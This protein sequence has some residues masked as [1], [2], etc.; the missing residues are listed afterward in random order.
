VKRDK[1][2]F[3]SDWLSDGLYGSDVRNGRISDLLSGKGGE[4]GFLGVLVV[5]L[6]I[7]RARVQSHWLYNSTK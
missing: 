4:E 3:G 2:T 1:V 5:I 7:L 6:S